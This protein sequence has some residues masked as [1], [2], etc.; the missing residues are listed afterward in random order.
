MSY[1][2]PQKHS[3]VEIFVGRWLEVVR[4]IVESLPPLTILNQ[5]NKLKKCLN[6]LAIINHVN[7]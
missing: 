7:I 5:K 6:Q 4:L 2:N 3:R 1:F